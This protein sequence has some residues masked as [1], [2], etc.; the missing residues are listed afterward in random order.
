MSFRPPQV[1][2]VIETQPQNLACSIGSFKYSKRLQPQVSDGNE[3]GIQEVA[4]V[5]K[6]EARRT[7]HRA[8]KVQDG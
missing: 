4:A 2:P 7:W 3:E 8:P 5:V 6:V 1:C